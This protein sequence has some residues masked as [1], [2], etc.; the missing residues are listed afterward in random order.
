MVPHR[1]FAQGHRVQLQLIEVD[2]EDEVGMALGENQV[3]EPEEVGG[4]FRRVDV[5]C[6]RVGRVLVGEASGPCQSGGECGKS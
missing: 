6:S 4:R 3:V 2:L 1:Q 5:R